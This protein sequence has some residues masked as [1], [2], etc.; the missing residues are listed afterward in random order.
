VKLTASLF[1]LIILAG[2]GGTTG[3][4]SPST[5]TTSPPPTSTGSPP[6]SPP[7]T[8]NP[9]SVAAGQTVSGITIAVVAPQA[10]PAPNAQDLGVAALSGTGS[11]YNTGDVI[12]LGATARV[13]LFGPGLDGSMQVSIVGPPGISVAGVAPITSTDKTPGVSFLATVAPNAALGARTVSLK[14]SQ[15]D[16]TTFTGGLEVVP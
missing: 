4:P 11:A 12:H 6:S 8:A 9:V 5:T 7:S 15:G 1:V 2:C 3:A 10:S 16:I 14:N 13:L